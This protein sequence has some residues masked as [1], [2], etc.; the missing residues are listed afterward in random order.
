MRL[1]WSATAERELRSVGTYIAGHN[2]SAATKAEARLRAA[3][4]HLHLF[5]L[6]GRIGHRLGTREIVITE[7]PYIIRYRLTADQVQILRIF[8]T[9]EE[10]IRGSYG[11]CRESRPACRI[12]SVVES[13]HGSRA[14]I[15]KGAGHTPAETDCRA[16]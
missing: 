8:H 12:V 11:C 5:P 16:S 4:E 15:E 2:P 14:V 3:V 6:A 13:V 10:A 1:V 9:R 7:Y